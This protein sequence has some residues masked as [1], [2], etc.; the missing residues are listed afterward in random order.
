MVNN[1]QPYGGVLIKA[2]QILDYL[3]T[4]P[5]PQRLSEIAKHT[6]LTNP[7][8]LKILNTLLLI[9]YVQKDPDTKMFSL[10]TR[11]I[12]YAN[13]SVEQLSIKKIAQ[14]HLESLQHSTTETVHLGILES[15]HIKYIAK[16]ESKKPVSLYSQI[17]K[18]IPL[19]CSAM[20]KAVLADLND[21]EVEN[22]LD[23]IQLIEKTKNTFTDKSMLIDELKKV[24]EQGYA[25]D[26]G[27]HDLEV[28]CVGSS[29]TIDGTNYGAISVSLPKYRLTDEVLDDLIKQTL[30][31][32]QNIISTIK[33][34]KQA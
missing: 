6:G 14:P 11:L 32:K 1:S 19:Y 15:D 21:H 18:S 33:N 30:L 8:A 23:K 13:K 9:G 2:D 24:R 10:G 17:G 25:F 34:E 26:N 3:S 7:T 5:Q 4:Q 22:Y 20:G 16:I 31:C 27:E 29:I 28:F 12:K